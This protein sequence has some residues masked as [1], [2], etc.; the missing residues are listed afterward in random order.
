MIR[1]LSR[2]VFDNLV[3]ISSLFLLPQPP[4][5]PPTPTI[6]PPLHT[7]SS[8][9]GPPIGDTFGD[10]MR[11]LGFELPTRGQG[12]GQGAMLTTEPSVAP[13]STINSNS[14]FQIFEDPPTGKVNEASFS[15]STP[16]SSS[17][18]TGAKVRVFTDA[19]LDVYYPT[20]CL[21]LNKKICFSVYPMFAVEQNT[22][23]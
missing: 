18:K 20:P 3:S 4:P 6:S 8:V 2:H 16:F 7:A 22:R 12:L 10:I 21:S 23:V 19:R 15:H 5:L 1:G 13:T 11:N 14:D 9:A 17:L